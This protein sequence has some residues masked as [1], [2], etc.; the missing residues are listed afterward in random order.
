MVLRFTLRQLMYFVAVGETGSVSKAAEQLNVSS[1][2]V[3]AAISQLEQEFGVQLFV[4]RHAQGV[5]LTPGGRLFL[6]Q[7]RLVL[8]QAHALH[9]LASD[10]TEQP[11]GPIRI[12]CLVTLAPV[13]LASL[14]RSFE[15]SHPEA[16]VSQVSGHQGHL[17]DMIRRAEIDVAITYDLEIPQDVI[18]D[19]LAALPPY[20][21]LAAND[22]NADAPAL[23]LKELSERPMVLL[24]LPISREYFLSMFQSQGLRPNVA[25]RAGDV[26][27]LHSLVAN[28]YGYALLNIRYQ[29]DT[30]P[31]GAKV[32]LV[33]LKGDFRPMILGLA[34]VRSEYEPNIVRAFRSHFGQAIDDDRI[35]GMTATD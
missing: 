16:V 21:L 27:M 19:P 1:P 29:I 33:P 10:I 18:F 9:D 30:A 12:G 23:T 31:D 11:R 2:S 8:G 34:R 5:T 22:P 15:R 35:P 4:R 14:R 3:S 7:S 6:T 26:A 17:L 28:G 13:I 20:V 25:E 24:D 32:R